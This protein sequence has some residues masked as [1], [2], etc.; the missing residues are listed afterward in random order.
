MNIA[1]NKIN[2]CII[3]FLTVI[4]SCAQSCTDSYENVVDLKLLY[5]G[6]ETQDITWQTQTYRTDNIKRTDS[7]NA[8]E[9]NYSLQVELFKSDP[10]VANGPRTELFRPDG[11]DYWVEDDE[12]WIGGSVFFSTDYED[13]PMQEIIWQIHGDESDPYVPFLIQSIND[14]LTI[15]G[16]GI[17]E[18]SVPKQKGSWTDIVVHHLWSSSYHGI[19]Q[20]FV[21]GSLILDAQ[22]ISNMKP[23]TFLY[24]KFG[25]YKSG[26]KQEGDTLSTVD[27]RKLWFDEIRIGYSN[28]NYADVAP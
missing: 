15:K 25:I 21:N 28:S 19:T 1:K 13:D 3:S 6:F 23:N 9:G 20:V 7:I 11:V 18:T 14:N 22:G 2:Y 10:W 16:N 24:W 12:I 17:S 26:W 5:D 27:Y 8:R 4:F